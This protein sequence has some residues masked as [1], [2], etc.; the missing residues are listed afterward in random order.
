MSDLQRIERGFINL[1][2]TA[3]DSGLVDA[4]AR[5][6]GV[7][8]PSRP[9]TFK[10]SDDDTVR[11][12]WLGPDE[13]LISAGRASATSLV[14]QLEDALAGHTVA[15]ND[16][17]GGTV[18]LE[19]PGDTAREVLARGCTLDLHPANFKEL[20]CAQSTLA[21]ANVLIACISDAPV[22]EIIVRRSFSEYVLLWLQQTQRSLASSASSS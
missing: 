9:N 3:D 1:R 13:W 22:Y 5:V 6:T 2:G 19:L 7:E 16:L 20:D 18:L 4:V 14:A 8:L 15:I 12:Y 21:K 11:A 17:S 10:R